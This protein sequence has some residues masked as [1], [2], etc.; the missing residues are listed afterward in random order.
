MVSKGMF[1]FKNMT[2]G[3][4]CL[5]FMLFQIASH[6]GEPLQAYPVPGRKSFN[7]GLVFAVFAKTVFVKF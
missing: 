4:V 3:C 6:Y 7:V 5:L 1:G 2:F